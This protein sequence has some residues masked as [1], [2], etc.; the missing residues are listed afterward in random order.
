MPF[1]HIAAHGAS[2]TAHGKPSSAKAGLARPRYANFSICTRRCTAATGAKTRISTGGGSAG[3]TC[4]PKIGGRK[5]HFGA[6]LFRAHA[7]DGKF[8]IAALSPDYTQVITLDL[9][10]GVI[11]LEAR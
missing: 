1:R 3:Q 4:R 10:A 6:G 2:T 7:T 5:R 9:D 11:D 8:A